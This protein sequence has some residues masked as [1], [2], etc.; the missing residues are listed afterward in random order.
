M[1][2]NFH[3]QMLARHD[4][5]GLYTV[6]GQG[7]I[8][9]GGKDGFELCVIRRGKPADDRT[10]LKAGIEFALAYFASG[11]TP[12]GEHKADAHDAHG[13]AAWDRWIA[14]IEKG[15]PGNMWRPAPAWYACRHL[16]AQCLVEAQTRI[17]DEQLVVLFSQAGAAFADA[18]SHLKPLADKFTGSTFNN[19]K[20][21][22]QDEA[23]R[24]EV[25]KHLRAAKA[26]DEKAM[27]LLERIVAAL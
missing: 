26:A 4:Q 21:W 11:S 24:H 10:A 8:P 20:K 22:L 15:D 16:A 6:K 27:K 18:A 3:Y 7:P 19:H 12:Q 2:H 5:K 1:Y 17:P 9:F 23:T 13:Q 14:H 25:L